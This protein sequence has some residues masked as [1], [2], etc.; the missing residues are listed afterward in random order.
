VTGKALAG[1]VR[2]LL[3]RAM[4]KIIRTESDLWGAMAE[5]IDQMRWFGER[6]EDRTRQGLPDCFLGAGRDYRVWVE[7]KVEQGR[8]RPG[9]QAW[10]VAAD[11]RG[12]RT[13]TLRCTFDQRFILTDTAAVARADLFGHIVPTPILETI[14]LQRA[15]VAALMGI[16]ALPPGNDLQPVQPMPVWPGKVT[17]PGPRGRERIDPHG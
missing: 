5:I 17:W 10:A 7:L 11:S 3:N 15:L 9:Q 1:K 4:R 12:E 6:F 13:R 2:A 16:E 8:Y 14:S